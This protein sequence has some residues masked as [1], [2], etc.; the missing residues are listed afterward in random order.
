MPFTIAPYDIETNGLL[1]PKRDKEGAITEPALD[2]VWGVCFALMDGKLNALRYISACDQPGYEKGKYHYTLPDRYDAEGF[3]ERTLIDF[4]VNAPEGATVW[5]RMPIV[6]ALELLATADVRVAHN[7]QDF[8]E[9]ALEQVY[10]ALWQR[11]KALGGKLLDTLL[12]SRVTYPDIHR[13]G[14]NR[15]KLFSFEQRQHGVGAW[16]KRL[17]VHKGEYTDWC[18]A[19]GIDPW[20]AWREEMQAYNELD[21]VVLI[22]I[23]KWLWAQN[24]PRVAVD[25][26]H[27]FA[28][29]IRRQERRGWAFDKDEAEKLAS[30]LTLL[31]AALEFRLIDQ[32]GAWWAPVKRGKGGSEEDLKRAWKDEEEDEDAEDDAEQEKRKGKFKGAFAH[33]QEQAAKYQVIP[34]MDRS[35]KML[36]FPDIVEPRFSEKTGRELKPY[37]GPP[38]MHFTQGN[39]YTPIKRVEFNPGSRAHI[40]QRL[41]LK[42]G[43]DPVKFTPGGKD[44]P[45]APVVD[46]E[47]LQGLPYPEA[48][49]L[50]EYFLVL[51][52][53]GQLASGRKAWLRF[54]RETELPNGK[55]LYRIHGRMN[56]NGA[57]TG[58]ATHSDPNMGQVP[59]NHA[60]EENYP[61]SPALHG[62]R[63]RRLFIASPGMIMAGFDGEA[64]E[65]RMLAHYV[66]PWDKGEY[67]SIVH[68]GDKKLGTDPHSWLRD[69]IGTDIMGTG[70]IGRGKAK[71]TMYARLYG[72]GALKIGR[73]I[74]PTGSEKE[75]LELGLMVK[76]RV[77]ERFVA[78]ASLQREV[79]A[80]VEDKGQLKGLDGRTL[81]I[82][83]PHAAL[84]SLLQSGGGVAMKKALVVHDK[85]LQTAGMKPGRDYEFIGNVH[86]EVQAEIL[87]DHKSV[88]AELAL[89]SLPRAGEFFK[90]RCPLTA[91][92]KFGSSWAD[93][94]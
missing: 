67:A 73:I 29:I 93:T 64:I 41:M 88:Y 66:S 77:A 9:R 56:T 15:H 33:M 7:G 13:T 52:R 72:A 62:I 57:A 71:T 89:Q 38:K 34:T 37:V 92:V 44:T 43:W 14:P 87:P 55:K 10:P 50:A 75:C 46:E 45:P 82:R 40:W 11:L 18:K 53:L 28:S 63:C 90:L 5:E 36:G 26:E 39:P 21:V 6:D 17:G 74:L 49:D 42:Y 68:N 79:Q 8:D 25:L 51:K 16:G 54:A 23:L 69:L 61:D 1:E 27:D 30:E 12:L 70:E 35:V 80:R 20:S 24:T 60:A 2:R 59:A 65:L 81:Y 3:P 78:E 31:E 76:A 58:R 91:E 85:A 19:R 48:K 32:F 86:D 94:H 83:K 47:V 4:P 22:P 84:N